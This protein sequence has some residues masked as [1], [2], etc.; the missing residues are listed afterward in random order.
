[1]A[2]IIFLIVAIILVTGCGQKRLETEYEFVDKPVLVCPTPQELNGGKPVPYRPEL[3]IHSLKDG[4][5]AGEVARAYEITIKQ[6]QGYSEVL[7]KLLSSYDRQSEE[8][9]KLKAIVDTLYPQGTSIP[10]QFGQ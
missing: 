8:Y 3:E 4:A 1:M 10:A 9:K 7:H 5:S 2:R 6:L